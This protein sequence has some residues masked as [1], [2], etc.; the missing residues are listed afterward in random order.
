MAGR[1]NR[2]VET[3]AAAGG[4]LALGMIPA[5]AP[6]AHADFEDLLLQPIT[7]LIDPAAAVAPGPA[8]AVDPA[9]PE[10][11][12]IPLTMDRTTEPL[13]NLSVGGG[14]SL[15]VLVDTGSIG[16]TLPA[17]DVPWQSFFQAWDGYG[18]AY[19]GG[20][21]DGTG[22]FF[23]KLP[24]TVDFTT[25][26]GQVITD[27]TD[28][29]VVLFSWPSSLLS[30]FWS[31]Q[32]AWAGSGADGVLGIGPDALG[33]NPG[34][35]P[36]TAHLPGDLG[37]G[38]LIDEPA[39]YLEFGPAPTD[40]G[41]GVTTAGV[42]N[43]ALGVQLNGGPIVPVA[44]AFIDSGDVN[45]QIPSHLVQNTPGGAS[46]PAGTTIS[47]YNSAGQQLYSYTAAPAPGEGPG[48]V[49]T[50]G[51]TVVDNTD[52][53]ITGYEAFQQGPVYIDY[54]GGPHGGATTTFYPGH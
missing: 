52:I 53:F 27:K 45:G 16:L 4:F 19:Y 51:P 29:D 15:P 38:V 14:P 26:T 33:P 13:V 48:G 7:D 39:G 42:D 3:V 23:V 9:V 34:V 17:S 21:D 41:P 18:T 8:A 5:A 12:T 54:A 36:P 49:F 31:F 43:T 1:R 32:S 30:P 37:Q 2:L 46:L 47:V 6:S 10:T 50:N 40:L 20:K 44:H 11:A 25:S 24:E 22:Y 28:V 35:A